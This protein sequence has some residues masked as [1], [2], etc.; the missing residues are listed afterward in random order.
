VPFDVHLTGDDAYRRKLAEFE[1]FLHDLRSFW[2]MLVP[3]VH[4]WMGAQFATEG[5]WGGQRWHALSPAYAVEKARSHPGRTILIRDGDLRQA[6]S[7]MRREASPRTLVMW[8][9]SPLAPIHQEGGANLPAR[10]LIPSPLPQSALREVDEA[11]D[12][13]VS[14]LVR[15]LGL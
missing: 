1:L 4:G 13:Y 5:S 7:R 2:P 11:A 8:I 10:P 15:R 12:V 3:I 6:A 14:T 9:D